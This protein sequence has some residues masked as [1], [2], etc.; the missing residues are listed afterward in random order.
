MA[1][2]V[3]V[4]GPLALDRVYEVDRLPGHDEKAMVRSYAEKAGGPPLWLATHLARWGIDVSLHSV[5]GNDADGAKVIAELERRG[6]D[7]SGIERLAEHRTVTPVVIVDQTGEKAILIDQLPDGV[8]A[9]VGAAIAPAYGDAIATN[10][11]HAEAVARIFTAGRQVGATSLLDL[12]LPELEECGF[13]TAVGLIEKA[14]IVCTNAQVLGWWRAAH[15]GSTDQVAAAGDFATRL[16]AGARTVC[17]TL[18]AAGAVVASA[19]ERLHVGTPTITPV[20]TTGAGDTFAAAFLK[21][22]LSGEDD[23]T[24]VRCAVA[25]GSLFVAA[26]PTDWPAV[27]ATAAT[28]PVLSL[29]EAAIR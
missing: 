6:L 1:P 8:L 12:E 24:A 22:R 17:V 20:N 7:T 11:F 5:L 19:E 28:L 13:D 26:R 27:T 10:L 14:D 23:G 2:R 4:V 9:R 25:A 21:A 18:G 29:E 15:Q 16:S 3:H